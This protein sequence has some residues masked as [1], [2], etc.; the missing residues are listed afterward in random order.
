MLI[1]PSKLLCY[2]YERLIT[3]FYKN[4]FLYTLKRTGDICEQILGKAA[5]L[6]K[7]K[8]NHKLYEKTMVGI[9]T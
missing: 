8:S 7:K 2:Y 1:I 3:N 4:L 5:H 9:D 6:L